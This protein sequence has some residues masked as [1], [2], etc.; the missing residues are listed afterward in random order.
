LRDLHGW[1]TI[2]KPLIPPVAKGMRR[3]HPQIDE[4]HLT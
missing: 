4:V 1:N 2:R 3:L